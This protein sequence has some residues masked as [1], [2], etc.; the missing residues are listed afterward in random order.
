[1]HHSVPNKNRYILCSLHGT[2]VQQQDM[3]L[4]SI[5]TKTDLEYVLC[6]DVSA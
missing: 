4:K 1:M 3:W 6:N 2:M 5:H